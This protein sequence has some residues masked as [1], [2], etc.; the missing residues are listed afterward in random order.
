MSNKNNKKAN[1]QTI[2]DVLGHK[3]KLTPIKKIKIA[4][5]YTCELC[6]VVKYEW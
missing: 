2:C 4:K 5:K 1:L 6:G 3:W